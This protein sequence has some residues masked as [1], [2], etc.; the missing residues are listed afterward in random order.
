MSPKSLLSDP[1]TPAPEQLPQRE[2]RD[3]ELRLAMIRWCWVELRF[4]CEVVL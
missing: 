3:D 4:A 2:K 1:K